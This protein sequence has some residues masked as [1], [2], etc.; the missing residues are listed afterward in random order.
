MDIQTSQFL[1][2]VSAGKR[3]IAKAVISLDA[4]KKALKEHTI[5]V[6][7]G[8]TNGYI[9]EELLTEIGQQEGFSKASFLR[10]NKTASGRT[11]EKG[12]FLGV[13]I[14]IEKG[15]WIKGKTIFDAGPELGREDVVLK[16]ANAV[17]AERKMAGIQIAN[18]NLGTSRPILEAYVGRQANLI[19]PIGLEKRVFGNIAEL[20]VRLNS[21][22]S[23][24]PRLLPITGTIITELEAISIL[25]GAKAEL[26]SAG[27]ILGAEGSIWLAVSGTAEQLK[28]ASKW[29]RTV[30]SE[31][32]FGE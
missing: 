30:S 24:G 15:N 2:T 18:A 3:L 16:G 12:P 1:L 7:C 21:A 22:S 31:P 20:A 27:G 5:V 9:A 23:A 17:D 11:A 32:A 10:G 6:V 4:V 14:V 29:I 13:D 19:L 8:S 25:S 28:T 26:V